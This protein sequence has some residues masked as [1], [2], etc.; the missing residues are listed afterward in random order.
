MY[1]T[2]VPAGTRRRVFRRVSSSLA[3]TIRIDAEPLDGSGDVSGLLEVCG[4]RWLFSKE[5]EVFALRSSQVVRKGFWDT[6]YA[7]FVIPD[8]D[9]RVTVHRPRLG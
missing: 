9:V 3:Q 4:S 5:P 8:R 2:A 1:E 7:V 6:R